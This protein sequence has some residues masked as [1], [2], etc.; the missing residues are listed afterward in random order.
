MIH[1][2][3]KF[4]TLAAIALL[5]TLAIPAK[6]EWKRV[7]Q[8]QGNNV[9]LTVAMESGGPIH[10]MYYGLPPIQF[11]RGSGNL[12]KI[13]RWGWGVMMARDCDGN[14]TPEDTTANLSRAG[15][16]NGQLNS[17]EDY[18]KLAALAAAGERMNDAS[19]RID[20]NRLYVSTDA[21]DINEWPAIFRE[22]RSTGGAPITH[23]AQTISVAFGD[24]FNDWGMASGCSIEH[25]F[26][27]LNFAESN[28]M[29]Y[30]HV[31]FRNMSEYNKWN[32]LVDFT[33]KFAGTPNGQVWQGMFMTYALANGTFIGDRDE[34]WAYHY[35]THSHMISDRNGVEGSFTG[36]T[37]GFGSMPL[38]LPEFKGVQMEITNYN[39]H[40]WNTEFGFGGN[41]EVLEGGYPQPR[42]YRY[43]VGRAWPGDP[44]YAPN[45]SPWTGGPLYG[46]PGTILPGEPRYNNWIW[47]T[48]NA[49][50]Q[51]MFYGELKDVAP[52]DSFSVD[53]VLMWVY[54]K[55]PP[56]QWPPSD[57]P[58][59]DSPT[60]QDQLSPVL[61]YEDVAK[62]VS[63][64]GFILPE[65]PSP[66]PL[67]IIPG[68]QQVTITWSDVNIHTP[69]AYYGFLQQYPELDPTHAYREYDFEGYR[70]YRSFVGPSDSHSEQLA[71]FSISAGNL[72]FFY[73]DKQADDTGRYRM[74]NGMRAWYAL[75]PYD[76]NYDPAAKKWFSLPDPAS[77]KTWNRP[78]TGLFTVQPR[79]DASNYRE[80]KL[81]GTAYDAPG[82]GASTVS[83]TI[84]T[85]LTG[86][87]TPFTQPSAEAGAV[88]DTAYMLTQA[89]VYLEPQVDI[90]AIPI[91]NEKITSALSV[92]LVVTDWGP[93]GYRAGRRYVA[94]ADANGN[95]ID[96]SAPFIVVRAG[97]DKGRL[98]VRYNYQVQADGA[99]LAVTASYVSDR[100]NGN[101][102][103]QIDLS[104]YKGADVNFQEWRWGSTD[105]GLSY[106][107]SDAWAAMV[108]TGQFTVTFGS[109]G[110]G[111]TATVVNTVRGEN[112]PFSPYL[113]SGWGFVPP[114]VS[115][116]DMLYDYGM[117]WGGVDNETTPQADRSDKLVESLPSTNKDD[118][119][120]WV[121]GQFWKFSNVSAMPTGTMKVT[122][123][124]G[125]WS[126]TEFTQYPDVVQPGDR[127]KIDVS[128]Y[129]LNP[130]DADLSKV[131]VV[132]NPYMASSFLDLSPDS[133]RIEFVNLPDRCTIRIYSLGGHLVN[134]LNHI[135]ANRYGWGNYTDQ[136][137]LDANGNPRAL[138]GW[139]NHGGTEPWNLR[140]RFGQTIA[141]G[142]YFFHVTDARGVN[143]TGKFY[144]IN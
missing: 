143:Y 88:A 91:I 11:P 72:Q 98:P 110:A 87:K 42:A 7:Y 135:G 10:S 24:A 74:E 43:A 17:L 45:I 76:N 52:R 51:Y 117:A 126:G 33:D 1:Y 30:C 34:T 140:N 119:Y 53:W 20:V 122:S 68:N 38:R 40:G 93:N 3:A 8:A 5:V 130:E 127:W 77:G 22:G 121:N 23:G 142:L 120:L 118:F 138:T 50:N 131:K 95:I 100:S 69:D 26:Y 84:F 61:A 85:T 97:G 2:K 62:I 125:D 129:S 107:G 80:A 18:D 32:P 56:F 136:D 78:G 46:W 55:N 28:N 101:M 144:V 6:A 36:Q 104:G 114:G 81:A 73:I 113:E 35:P 58:S 139:D 115:P 71:D 64:G 133:R 106:T 15:Y 70:L 47:G 54:P 105:K 65:T 4:F 31:F 41:E 16:F 141:S 37:A 63:E 134:V 9:G 96:S 44:F 111:V 67:T 57:I 132:P 128:P 108:K 92:Y 89:P 99:T 59:I 39:A 27:F 49:N 94:F 29:V 60:V 79:S 75:V 82:S 116:E 14:G 21:D 66:P 83:Q 124:Y 102:H 137:R 19:T 25:Q 86:A 13:G 112:V 103:T 12:Y 123:A 109:G 48:L 90:Q